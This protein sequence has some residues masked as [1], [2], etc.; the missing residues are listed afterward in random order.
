MKP[1]ASRSFPFH[2][3]HARVDQGQ[4]R[5]GEGDLVQP[6]RVIHIPEQL[7]DGLWDF[8]LYGCA[9][10]LTLFLLLAVIAMSTFLSELTSNTAQ[11]ATMLPLPAA[12]ARAAGVRPYILLVPCTRAASAVFMKPVGTPPNAI[13]SGTGLVTIGNICRASF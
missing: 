11:V 3:P 12:F 4:H 1:S 8:G 6:G 13:V 5:A 9:V 7:V 10:W 2:D